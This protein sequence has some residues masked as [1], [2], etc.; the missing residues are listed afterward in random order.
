MR[1]ACACIPDSECRP[2]LVVKK[3]D[4]VEK[5]GGAAARGEAFGAAGPVRQP[6]VIN[7]GCA[8]CIAD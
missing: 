4:D 2:L 1:S 7:L 5:L 8:R 6:A 3:A